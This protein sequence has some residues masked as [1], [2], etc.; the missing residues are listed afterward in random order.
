MSKFG[1]TLIAHGLAGEVANQNVAC[2]A[3]WPATLIES[4][5]TINFQI[6]DRSMWRKADILADA[7]AAICSFEPRELTGNA[8]TDEEALRMVGVEDFAPYACVEGS[9]PPRMEQL[10]PSATHGRGG[11]PFTRRPRSATSP[12]T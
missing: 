3:L 12:K 4:Q 8:L 2:N 6:G 1:M 9:A 10:D 5:A 11:N 7:T